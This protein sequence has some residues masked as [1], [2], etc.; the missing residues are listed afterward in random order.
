MT[1]LGQLRGLGSGEEPPDGAK[2]RVYAALLSSVQVAAATAAAAAAAAKVDQLTDHATREAARGA[3]LSQVGSLKLAAL[4]VGA[5]LL[6]GV[7]GAGIYS[8]LRPADVK[9]VYV[10]RPVPLLA[11]PA[12]PSAV[13]VPT[14]VASR[15]KESTVAALKPAAV[16]E[17]EASELARERALLDQARRSAAHGDA[18]AA[19]E[20]AERHRARFPNGRLAEE[21]EALAIRALVASGQS[22]AARQRAQAFRAAYPNSLFGG[23]VDPA[24]SEP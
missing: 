13:P 3:L 15:I 4:S 24:A 20:M 9:I 2:E 10:D 16:F 11:P 14:P 12:A 19:L 5:L 6:G 18:T 23:V 7:A 1:A 22:E 17:T 8:S 21:R